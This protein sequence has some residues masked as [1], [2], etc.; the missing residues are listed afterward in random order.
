[1]WTLVARIVPVSRDDVHSHTSPSHHGFPELE[2]HV[3]GRMCACIGES[4]A[5]HSPDT[6]HSSTAEVREMLFLDEGS[7]E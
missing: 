6:K 1:M 7:L 4:T 3:W 2:T 5:N